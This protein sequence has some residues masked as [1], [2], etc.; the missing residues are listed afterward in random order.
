MVVVVIVSKMAGKI[1]N[2]D[3]C[4]A[5]IDPT[6]CNENRGVFTYI[7]DSD[8]EGTKHRRLNLCDSCSFDLYWSIKEGLKK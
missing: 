3:N 2:C 1:I 5:R 6:A 8:E 4:G 7:T